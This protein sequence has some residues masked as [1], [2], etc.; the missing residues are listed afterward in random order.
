[1]LDSAPRAPQLQG[2]GAIPIPPALSELR[3]E[4]TTSEQTLKLLLLG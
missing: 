4:T 2:A 3:N 1:M